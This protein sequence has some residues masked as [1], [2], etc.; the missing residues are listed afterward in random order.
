MKSEDQAGELTLLIERFLLLRQQG[1][2]LSVDQLCKDA[3]HLASAVSREL[4]VLGQMDHLLDSS[5]PATPR[6]VTG[7]DQLG[8]RRGTTD[9]VSRF[10]IESFYAHGGCS[11]V[12]IARDESLQ[13]KV[14]VKFLRPDTGHLGNYRI[15]L[16]REAEITS[17]LDHPGVVSVHAIGTDQQGLPFYA[18]QW[19]EGESLAEAIDRLHQASD[20]QRGFFLS[21]DARRLLNHFRDVCQT[22]AFAHSRQVVHR[23]LKPANIVIGSF[24]ESYVIDWGLARRLDQQEP[25]QPTEL[26]AE[27]PDSG[28]DT[29]RLTRMG[30]AMGSPAFMSPEQA[31][32][33]T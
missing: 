2:D 13:R 14:A 26:Q 20:G 19:I 3:P 7:A 11:E 8:H 5:E 31:A 22:I 10:Q 28:T 1:L 25:E 32:G 16:Q 17:R 18:M 33:K 30:H 9:A 24:G 27:L 21:A 23:D 15:R 29:A 6:G 4:E 12:Y